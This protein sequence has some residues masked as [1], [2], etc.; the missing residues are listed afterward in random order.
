MTTRIP[1]RSFLGAGA[2]AAT[3]G[4]TG[5]RRVDP[6]PAILGGPPARPAARQGVAWPIIGEDDLAG[7]V[8]VLRSGVW[9]RLSG[10]R[11]D[12]FESAWAE[13]LGASHCLATANG[14]GALICALNALDV[15]PGDEVIVP[16][17][18][19][20][21]TINAVLM[22]H[23][24][25]VFV[26]TDPR[27]FQIDAA[28]V[29]AAITD[30]TRAILPVH[31][32][33]APADLDT[34][35]EVGKRR[36][37]AVVEDACQAHLAEWRGQKVGTLG[38]CG[39]FSFQA[40]KN[41]NCGEGGALVTNVEDLD[42]QARSFQNNGRSWAGAPGQYARTGANLRLTEFQGA[43]LSTQLTRLEDQSR[44]RERNAAYLTTR[45]EAIGGLLPVRPHDGC[46]RNSYHL[47]MCR[48]D[49]DA[50]AGLTR[51]KFLEAMAA[52]GVGA[53]GG[54]GPLNREPFLRAA[55]ES[56]GYRQ[57]YG[58]KALADLLARNAEACPQND[59]VCTEAVWLGQ[60]TL[61]GPRE[62]MD[63]IALAVE[64]IKQNA[65]RI[66]RA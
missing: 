35:L 51:A 66:S 20:V 15:G 24:L 25:P 5:A 52:E 40:S 14:T 23:A 48:Y 33:G 10:D 6:T 57:V 1:R 12:R 63:A 39:C 55:F 38:D 49:P 16:P 13:R 22:Q 26:D 44:T 45:L 43:L 29:E 21:A 32:G 59:R 3:L 41:L 30:R 64:K 62:E 65:E 60:T 18:T 58:E 7:W 42:R 17:Y 36:K 53:S 34:L 27:T 47:Y 4:L 2:T 31:V 56:R 54:Y 28:K 37:V 8:D 11:V 46:T 9:N 50:F 19:F 61:L